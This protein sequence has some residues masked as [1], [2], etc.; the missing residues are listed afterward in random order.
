MS[1]IFQVAASTRG[2]ARGLN[3]TAAHTG[4][5]D[6]ITAAMLTAGASGGWGMLRALRSH[7]ARDERYFGA[8]HRREVASNRDRQ[9]QAA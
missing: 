3:Q 1:S 7:A 5:L 4:K 8:Q 2:N 9:C 6:A